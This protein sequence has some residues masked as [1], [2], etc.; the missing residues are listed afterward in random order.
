[1]EKRAP[2]SQS[3][4]VREMFHTRFDINVKLQHNRNVNRRTDRE[5]NRQTN[6]KV[7]T[8]VAKSGS[9]GVVSCKV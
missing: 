1:M 9:Q 2:M 6:G 7:G 5:T 4:E 8:Y 3:Q